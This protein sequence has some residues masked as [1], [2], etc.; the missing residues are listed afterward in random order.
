VDCDANGT[1]YSNAVVVPGPTTI[2]DGADVAQGATTDAEA[3]VGNGTVI[4]LLKRLRTL[5][6]FGATVGGGAQA[7]ALRVTLANDSTG[8]VD[9]SDRAARLVGRVSVLDAADVTQ[10]AL[11]DAAVI[12][13][14]NGSLSGKLR[15]L[16]KWA[17][18][19]MPATLGQGTMAQSLPVVVAS[20]Q[21]AV[22]SS[23]A[24]GSDVAEGATADAAIITD[25]VGSLS[26]KLRGLVKWAF[27]RMPATLGQGTMA[28]S[29]PVVVA[30]NQSGVPVTNAALGTGPDSVSY[31]CTPVD[32]AA[33]ATTDLVAAPG[34]GNMIWVYGL[35]GM[36]DTA[37]GTVRLQD[38]TPTAISGTMAVSDEGGF[39]LPV[40]GNLSMPWAKCAPN[41][42]LQLVTVGCTFDGMLVYG[43]ASV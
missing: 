3:A 26:G 25:A 12:T 18:E 38:S 41:T 37:A 15:G 8:V 33:G 22:P 27:E 1:L 17:F 24:D 36:A 31:H 14:A 39:V 11:G 19:R 6:G 43:V 23:V 40:T 30:S 16:V 34:E 5:L 32:C 20:N 13:D 7:A 4:A 21:T 28:Q 10:G 9:V 35:F 2:A 42:K 29:L